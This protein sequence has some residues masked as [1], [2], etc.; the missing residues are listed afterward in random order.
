MM[1][2]DNYHC[3]SDNSLSML[4]YSFILFCQTLRYILQSN[5]SEASAESPT[6]NSKH[7]EFH[8]KGLAHI[9]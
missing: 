9:V 5:F 1:M 3:E 6:D 8:F 4:N 2:L 7:A